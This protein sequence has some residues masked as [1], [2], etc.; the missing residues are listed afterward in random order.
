MP[1]EITLAR[2]AGI[3]TVDDADYEAVSAHKWSR[4]D[5]YGKSYIACNGGKLTLFTFLMGPP[6]TQ[7]YRMKFLNNDRRDFRRENLQWTQSQ[8]ERCGQVRGGAGL[9]CAKCHQLRAIDDRYAVK[10]Q[11]GET[12]KQGRVT[13]AYTLGDYLS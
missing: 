11:R 6:P 3:V 7:S 13:M 8:C 9:L 10:S 4:L 12:I 5:R 2:G 1:R